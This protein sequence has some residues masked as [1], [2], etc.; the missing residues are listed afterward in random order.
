M[1]IS[2]AGAEVFVLLMGCFF[3]CPRCCNTE[4][5]L[6]LDSHNLRSNLTMKNMITV[7]SFN[8]GTFDRNDD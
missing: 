3:F 7:E 8:K 2:F 4:H 5:I 6:K 1:S